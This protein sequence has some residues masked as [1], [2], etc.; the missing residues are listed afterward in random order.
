MSPL[1]GGRADSMPIAP[2]QEAQ[3]PRRF[4]AL[5]AGLAALVV[6]AV[7]SPFLT[8]SRRDL[9]PN[10]ET[11]YSEIVHE[12]SGN[13]SLMVLTLDGETY[14]HKPPLQF[15][16][17][18]LF[19]RALGDRTAWPFVLPS[20]IGFLLAI[21][22]VRA[23]AL[24]MFGRGA[25]TALFV[26]TTFYF[27]WAAAQIARM[28]AFF[29]A[30]IALGMLFV[31]RFLE[32]E[33]SKQLLY[34][35]VAIGLAILTKGPMALVI[36][37]GT[38]LF[39][40]ARRRRLPSGPYV[41][42]AGIALAVPL[43]WLVPAGIAG[44]A[45]YIREL[46]F[47]QNAGR[48]VNALDHNE[49]FWFYVVRF[50]LIFFPWGLMALIAAAAAVRNRIAPNLQ[51]AGFCTS[52]T[53]AV[54]V[55]FS[56]ISG[57]L[58]IYMLPAFV[59]ASLLIAAFLTEPREEGWLRATHVVNRTVVGFLA[60][61]FGAAVMVPVGRYKD[62]AGAIVS[63]PAIRGWLWATCAFALAVLV[64]QV[65]V[66]RRRPLTSTI[67]VGLATMFPL[68]YAVVA[69]APVIN[70]VQ[71]TGVLVEALARQNVPWRE[72]ALVDAPY[73]WSR[74]HGGEVSDV[75]HLEAEEVRDGQRPELV[76][77][78]QVLL[79]RARVVRML[80][81]YSKVDEVQVRGRWFF[82]Y[83]LQ[84]AARA[85]PLPAPRRRD[86]AQAQ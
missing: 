67:L 71:S 73:L 33:D 65:T 6:L 83:R 61:V 43:L 4:S 80:E 66:A 64:A 76:V 28:D 27:Q 51:A 53:L 74:A 44:G 29:S 57:K 39:E 58:D 30:L 22:V 72:I 59:P 21:L 49:P 35:A 38:L 2:N 78:H 81:A 32:T 5:N 16:L 10:D 40:W 55:P 36:A 23:F 69:L 82:I 24:R 86:R 84:R 63:T 41:L 34:A 48:I 52:W 1:T 9:Y 11:R 19:T 8:P 14:S 20:L 77:T 37:A 56:L 31:W 85:A 42:A 15:W 17:M 50:P 13:D 46:V 75:M 54:L 3:S 18:Y 79:R 45:G 62:L 68:I 70:R 12:M 47:E 25:L 26:F 60:L 7:L